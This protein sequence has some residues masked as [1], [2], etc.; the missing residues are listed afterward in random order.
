MKLLVS[1]LTSALSNGPY[2]RS[3]HD[4]QLS[5][6]QY[7][8]INAVN[9]IKQTDPNIV[10]IYKATA[11]TWSEKGWNCGTVIG[12]IHQ[13]ADDDMNRRKEFLPVIMTV[14]LNEQMRRQQNGNRHQPQ[15]QCMEILGEYGPLAVKFAPILKKLKLS[16][17]SSIRE[18]AALALEKVESK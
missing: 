17:E 16:S 14:I 15:V 10:E 7:I 18:A 5:N 3:I 13:W 9:R 11:L 8:L 1:H 4:G 2:E 6:R 12:H